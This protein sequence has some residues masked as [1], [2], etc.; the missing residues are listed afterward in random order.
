MAPGIIVTIAVA[1]SVQ[2]TSLILW[3]FCLK[4]PDIRDV[5]DIGKMLFGGSEI[6]YNVT[7]VFFILNNTFIQGTLQTRSFLWSSVIDYRT[8]PALHCLVGAKLLN[9]LTNGHAACTVVWSVVT[10]VICFFVS[11]P[12]PLSQLSILGTISAVTMGIAVL[13]AIIF[14]GIQDHPFKYISGQEPLVTR[15]PLPGTTYVAGNAYFGCRPAD[16]S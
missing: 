8:L 10:T 6:A 9:T 14:A 1:L 12:R 4:H 16:M 15:L 5:C 11:L 2:Y 13:L 3:K 7:A